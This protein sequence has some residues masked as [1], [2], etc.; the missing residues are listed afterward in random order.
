MIQQHCK[1][2]Y[3]VTI[4]PN[5]GVGALV[6]VC[7]VSNDENGGRLWKGTLLAMKLR[8]QELVPR[9]ACT[10]EFAVGCLKVIPSSS[11]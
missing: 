11:I 9:G 10:T 7:L 1:T 5:I 2:F 4:E 6:D 8:L 3:K